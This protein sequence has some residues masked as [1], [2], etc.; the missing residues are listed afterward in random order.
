MIKYKLIICSERRK[1]RRAKNDFIKY[2]NQKAITIYIISIIYSISKY[3]VNL[4]NK[5][6]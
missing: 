6:N 2:D 5:L 1:K 3:Q 4:I